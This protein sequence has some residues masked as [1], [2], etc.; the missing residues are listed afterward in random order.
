MLRRMTLEKKK[1]VL[2]GNLKKGDGNNAGLG[3][4]V[5]SGLVKERTQ[6]AQLNKMQPKKK[7]RKPN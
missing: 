3:L 7:T 4:V 6:K 5:F 2:E 1:M